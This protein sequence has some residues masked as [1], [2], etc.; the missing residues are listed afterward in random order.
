MLSIIVA[1]GSNRAI[2][3]DNKLLW[4]LPDDLKNF[5]ALTMG[6]VMIMGRKTFES[7]GRVLP[8]R[9]TIVI[10]RNPE[11]KI[12]GA[13]CVSS[14]ESALELSKSLSSNEEVFVVGGG[15]IYKMALEHVDKIYLSVVDLSPEA[16]TYFPSFKGLSL[17]SEKTHEAAQDLPAWKFQV[18][19]RP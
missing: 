2:G 6:S 15:E 5:K 14:F 16:D 12:E 13:H 19:S 7:I 3:R 1:M 4:H 18:W 9:Q 10:S 11:L 8:G 17:E